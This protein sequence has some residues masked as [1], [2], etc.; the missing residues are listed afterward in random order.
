MQIVFTDTDLGRAA[1]ALHQAVDLWSDTTRLMDELGGMLIDRSRDRFERQQGPDGTAWAAL[2]E[3]TRQRR[4]QDAQPLRDSGALYSGLHHEPHHGYVVLAGQEIYTAIHQL[5]GKAGRNRSA[6]IP[7]RPF[8]PTG[9]LPRAEI[10]LAAAII[11]DAF[12]RGWP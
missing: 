12:A 6:D 10:A 8:L 9:G 4:G 3:A 2:S 11:S 1:Q 5:G 7:A